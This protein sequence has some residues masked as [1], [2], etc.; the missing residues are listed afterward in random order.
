MS[1]NASSSTDSDSLSETKPLMET[2][3][4]V[5]RRQY[6]DIRSN[7]RATRESAQVQV[8]VILDLIE[9]YK[10]KNLQTVC[11]GQSSLTSLSQKKSIF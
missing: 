5:N 9:Y 8:I 11:H 2:H 1:L 10:I 6:E 7:D 4:D 3:V